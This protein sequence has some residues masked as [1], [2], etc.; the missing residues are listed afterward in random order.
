MFRLVHLSD[1]HLGPIP[2]PRPIDLLGKRFAGYMN[3]L[4]RRRTSH[5]MALLD[6]MVADIHAQNPHHIA[7]VG[8]LVNISLPREFEAAAGFLRR[9]GDPSKTSV[10]PGNHD[11]YVASAQPEISRYWGPWM[12]TDSGRFEGFP[13]IRM[14]GP[15]ALIGLCSGISTWPLLATGR[16]G[17]AQRSAFAKAMRFLK[18]QNLA[19]VVMIHHPPYRGAA[20]PG[21]TLTDAAEFESILAETGAE[22]VLHGHNHRTEIAYLPGPD[23]FVPIVGAP[24]ASAARGTATHRA[25]YHIFDF[26]M[27]ERGVAITGTTRGLLEDGSIGHLGTLK[28]KADATT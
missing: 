22:L 7:C 3:W 10:V 9:L 24:S 12:T 23:G 4:M 6:R 13:F 28:L 21:R 11:A 25:G 20:K 18:A 17:A 14:A 27:T 8:D 1:P 26:D 5:D 19:R 16:L 15:I 2:T